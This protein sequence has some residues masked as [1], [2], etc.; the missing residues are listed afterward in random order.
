MSKREDVC[1]YC[2][3][4]LK[5]KE[6][7]RDHIPPKCLIVKPYPNDLITVPSCSKCNMGFSKLDEYFKTIS[8][9]EH[10]IVE[11]KLFD[12]VVQSS[13]RNMKRRTIFTRDFI[14]NIKIED[15]YTP[16]G[17]YLGKYPT[18]YI[19]Y[20]KVFPFIERVVKGLLYNHKKILVNANIKFSIIDYLNF[21]KYDSI[22]QEVFS[23]IINSHSSFKFQVKAN[24]TIKYKYKF[25][26][27]D[28]IHSTW[29]IV[30]FNVIPFGVLVTDESY[31]D[32]INRSDTVTL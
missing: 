15:T 20:K 32:K 1:I 24:Q 25:Y 29:T 18:Y 22:I 9:F 4:K 30:F 10:N 7:T 23:N 11:Q 27:N 2:L 21:K 19:E 31:I 17:I 6:I 8:S 26:S 14:N 16:A 12:D 13:M 3:R 28:F 5:F